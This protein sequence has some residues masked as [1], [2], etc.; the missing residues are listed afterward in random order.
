MTT[1]AST[2]YETTPLYNEN[3]QEIT[4]FNLNYDMQNSNIIE[5]KTTSDVQ[6]KENPNIYIQENSKNPIETSTDPTKPLYIEENRKSSYK[7]FGNRISRSQNSRP[8]R[9]RNFIFE[10]PKN[11]PKVTF[12]TLDSKTTNKPKHQFL[13]IKQNTNTQYTPMA[14]SSF[15]GKVK[16]KNDDKSLSSQSLKETQHRKENLKKPD[17]KN[18]YNID[19]TDNDDKEKKFEIM[20]KVE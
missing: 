14:K 20:E 1:D 11:F 16:Y 17:I 8:Q 10:N 15:R 19:Y 2:I 6:S 12:S 13:L 4:R 3:E 9:T 5:T 7:Y 18:K